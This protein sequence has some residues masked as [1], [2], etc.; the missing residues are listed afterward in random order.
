M[1]PFL[2]RLGLLAGLLL[3]LPASHTIAADP[4]E[5]WPIRSGLPWRSGVGLSYQPFEK[6]RGRPL[7]VYV[8]WHPHR[9]WNQIREANA[10]VVNRTLKGKPARLSM[11]IAMLPTTHAGQFAECAAGEFDDHYRTVAGKLVEWGRGDAI[12]RIGWEAN[13]PRSGDGD[14]GGG[15]PWGIEGDVDNYVAC[16]RR[17]V[18]VMRAVSPDFLIEWTM[19]K[20]TERMGGRAISDA[21]PGDGYVDIVGID[22]YD[23][24]P[25][26]ARR[27]TWDEDF[28]A[29]QDR[30]PRG[31]GAWLAFAKRHGKKLAVPEWGVRNRRRVSADNAGYVEWMVE[32]FR[33]HAEDLAYEAYFNPGSAKS[34][35]VFSIYPPDYN[36]GASARY[37][38]L[39][40]EP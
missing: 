40:G 37:L 38:E 25:A 8:T 39:Y 19:K 18:E 4:T 3:A 17:I 12:L 35:R 11:G 14:R 31:L 2:L 23:G 34:A 32:F 20:D 28:A 13:G 21:W 16:F 15:Y 9:T 5:G 36:P 29:E 10:E 33:K 7:D 1:R 26:Y 27:A 6:W 24:Y 22:Y 30:G